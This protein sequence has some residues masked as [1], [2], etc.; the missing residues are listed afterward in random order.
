MVKD[1]LII[2]GK[3]F[4]A[5]AVIVIAQYG[6]YGHY[7]IIGAIAVYAAVYFALKPL[8]NKIIEDISNNQ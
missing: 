2:I 6:C 8:I 5:I 3:V 7:K 4:L 1:Y